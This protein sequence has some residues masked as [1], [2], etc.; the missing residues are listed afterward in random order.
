MM[1]FEYSLLT[2]LCRLLRY[3]LLQIQPVQTLLSL[4][5]QNLLSFVGGIVMGFITSWCV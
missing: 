2:I 4:T 5:L 1:P 3:V